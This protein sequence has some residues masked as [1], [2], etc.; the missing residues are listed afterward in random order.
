MFLLVVIAMWTLLCGGGEAETC[1]NPPECLC[2][3]D[4]R[5]LECG[6]VRELPEFRPIQMR[7]Y[8]LVFLAGELADVPDFT[9]WSYLQTVD[10]ER[11]RIPCAEI[12]EWRRVASYR[13]GARRCVN[14]TG[15]YTY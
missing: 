15:M 14:V 6:N 7:M 13:V 5:L 12:L 9:G 11:T 1:G 10:V 8:R 4:V 3:A 2:H